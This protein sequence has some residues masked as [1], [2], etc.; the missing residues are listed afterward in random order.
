MNK[1]QSDKLISSLLQNWYAQYK[2]SLPWRETKDPYVVWISEIILQ[3]TRVNQ[4]IDYF[5]RF[6]EKFPDI[7]SL[8]E[9]PEDDVLKIWQGLG[10]YSR[11][12]NLHSAA[13]QIMEK[14]DEVFPVSYSDILS[15]TG[16]GEYTAAA[17]ASIIYNLPYAVVDGNV[18]RVLSRLFAIEVPID[19]TSGKNLF[20]ETAQSILDEQH[21]GNHNQAIMELGALVCTPKQPKCTECPLQTVCLAFEKGN[22]LD[23]PVKKGKTIQKERFFI[24]FHIEQNGYTYIKKR[25]NSDV[26][27]NLYEFPLIETQEQSD[28]LKLQANSDFLNLFQSVGEVYFQHNLRL[29][30]ELSH[31]IIHADFYRVELSEHSTFNFDGKFI[32]IESASLS[33]YPVSRL[34]HKYLETIQC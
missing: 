28:L 1:K 23:F 34:I 11:A 8:A 24:Y 27:K 22:V 10:Y 5:L 31:R 15:L 20:S 18:F 25:D 33:E 17:V 30:H 14:F 9:A 13:K 16:V 3:Q 32:K 4:G 26:W 19:S 2:R 6:V 29:K 21:P 12:R 7:K